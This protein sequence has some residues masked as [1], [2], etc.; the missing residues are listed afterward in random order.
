MEGHFLGS[1]AGSTEVI[2]ACAKTG[3][4]AGARRWLRHM[5]VLA[6]FS[7]WGPVQSGI[8]SEFSVNPLWSE[9]S[10]SALSM[11]RFSWR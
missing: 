4:M 8:Q 7:V 9:L 11:A 5:R 10:I 2:H 1:S 6:P 3:N